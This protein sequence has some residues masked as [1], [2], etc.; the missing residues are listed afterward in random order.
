MKIAFMQHLVISNNGRKRDSSIRVVKEV[1][2]CLLREYPESFNKGHFLHGAPNS[3]PFVR[4]IK[5]LLDEEKELK[6]NVA[7]LQKLQVH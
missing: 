5:T 3:I 6:E 4:R 1:V 7:Y 2:A